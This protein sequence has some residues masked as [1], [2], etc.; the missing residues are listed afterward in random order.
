MDPVTSEPRTATEEIDLGGGGVLDTEDVHLEAVLTGLGPLKS[1]S[2]LLVKQR[3]Q[4]CEILTGC[5][6]ENRFT[7]TGP[8]GDTVYWAKEHSSC[9]DR[10]VLS[11]ELNTEYSCHHHPGFFAA[12]SEHST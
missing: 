7:I 2:R 1:S 8:Q 11:H 9:L 12:T 5:E 6:Q 4:T 3:L 10:W